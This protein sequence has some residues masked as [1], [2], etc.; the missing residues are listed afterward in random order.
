[1]GFWFDDI[2]TEWKQHINLSESAWIIVLEDI[3]NFFKTSR[4]KRLN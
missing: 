3:K 2:S 1:M 4:R